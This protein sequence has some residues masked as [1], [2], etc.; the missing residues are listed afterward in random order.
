MACRRAFFIYSVFIDL[1]NL[2]NW[3]CLWVCDSYLFYTDHKLKLPFFF[4][5]LTPVS[6]WGKIAFCGIEPNTERSC[7]EDCRVTMQ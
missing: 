5:F 3:V 2:N 1:T 6:A 4:S 7:I